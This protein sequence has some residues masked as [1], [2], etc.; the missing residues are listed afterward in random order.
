MNIESKPGH[1]QRLKNLSLGVCTDCLLPKERS[2][3]RSSSLSG[4]GNSILQRMA[5]LRITMD[6]PP[7]MFIARHHSEL[8]L[9]HIIG[10]AKYRAFR[11]QARASTNQSADQ[12]RLACIKV[13]GKSSRS[14]ARSC[15]WDKITSPFLCKYHCRRAVA[16]PR[17]R[18]RL[19]E[20][21]AVVDQRD[22][23]ENRKEVERP[24]QWHTQRCDVQRT[25]H[26]AKQRRK[27]QEERRLRRQ[28]K[29]TSATRG[30][31]AKIPLRNWASLKEG[32]KFFLPIRR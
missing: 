27:L 21:V 31:H 22:A 1:H 20:G 4:R 9:N 32:G 25:E 8:T 11:R 17:L 23:K 3:Q 28:H 5:W 19:R 15:G 2:D 12:L 7:K 10:D 24:A 14:R 29:H 26:S 18:A 13:Q 6:P 16:R 30:K